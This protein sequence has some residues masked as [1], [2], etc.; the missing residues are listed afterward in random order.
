MDYF[1]G[2]EDFLPIPNALKVFLGEVVEVGEESFWAYLYDPPE[3]RTPTEQIEVLKAKLD[4]PELPYLKEGSVFCLSVGYEGVNF[5]FRK[6]PVWT[7]EQLAAIK[8]RAEL[9]FEAFRDQALE[10]G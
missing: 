4:T 10:K 8:A 6:G 3:A 5:Q 7:E 2:W 9:M 1:S